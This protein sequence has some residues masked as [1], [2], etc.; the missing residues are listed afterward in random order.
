MAR[1]DSPTLGLFGAFFFTSLV[2]ITF[3]SSHDPAPLQLGP[4]PA[5]ASNSTLHY[6]LKSS[7]AH[8]SFPTPLVT[9]HPSITSQLPTHRCESAPLYLTLICWHISRLLLYT[10]NTLHKSSAILLTTIDT[11][12]SP[13]KHRIVPESGHT[14]VIATVTPRYPRSTKGPPR[15]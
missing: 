8:S 4:G 14:K 9:G 6:A 15:R 1:K 5:P 13:H 10:T 12:P 7:A 3:S 2:R 11:F